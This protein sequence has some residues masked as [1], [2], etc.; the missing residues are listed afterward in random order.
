MTKEEVI[1][2]LKL[3]GSEPPHDRSFLGRWFIRDA[4]FRI[5]KGTYHCTERWVTHIIH[6]ENGEWWSD[7]SAYPWRKPEG[8]W[9]EIEE[10]D[11]YDEEWYE[12][13]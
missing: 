13:R 8:G 7:D 5:E 3:K 6:W 11:E 10:G 4:T 12:G 9:R 2:L 1:K